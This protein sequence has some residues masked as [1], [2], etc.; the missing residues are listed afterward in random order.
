MPSPSTTNQP[1]PKSWDEFED[2]C[3]D[4][5]KRIWNDPYIVRHGRSGQKQNGVDCYGLPLHLGGASEK[6]YAGAQCKKVTS[7]SI[8]VIEEEVRK[9]QEFEPPLEE[10]LIMTTAPRDSALQK[11]I[12]T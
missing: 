10:Y 5:L 1:F 7:I 12:R 9:A 4:I 11:E 6:R 3:A 2:I 8:H